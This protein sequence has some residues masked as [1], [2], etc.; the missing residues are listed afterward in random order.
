M[1]IVFINVVTKR[2][3][4]HNDENQ[5]TNPA[6]PVF[7]NQPVRNKLIFQ[8]PKKKIEYFYSWRRQTL[9]H[10]G[11]KNPYIS[12]VTLLAVA[13]SS[14]PEASSAHLAMCAKVVLPLAAAETSKGSLGFTRLARNLLKMWDGK[15][16]K[17]S[18]FQVSFFASW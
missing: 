9:L 1:Y 15:R 7:C 13:M 14:H 17:S 18:I 11:K 4:T 2:L 16:E 10:S 5:L 3:K 12:L 6:S 8:P